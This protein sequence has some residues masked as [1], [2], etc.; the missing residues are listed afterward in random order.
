MK[1]FIDENANLYIGFYS[2]IRGAWVIW[3]KEERY[4]GFLPPADVAKHLEDLGGLTDT[5]TAVFCRRAGTT[6]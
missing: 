4:L 6:A 5:A 1:V 2:K 3:N